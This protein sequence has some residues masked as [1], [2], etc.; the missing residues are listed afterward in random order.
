MPKSKQKS[1]D[2]NIYHGC[3]EENCILSGTIKITRQFYFEVKKKFL[4]LEIFPRIQLTVV[5]SYIQSLLTT[6]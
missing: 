4:Q 1:G 6:V 3:L 5:C 2:V